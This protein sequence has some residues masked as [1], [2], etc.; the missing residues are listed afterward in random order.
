MDYATPNALKNEEEETTASTV[1]T[2]TSKTADLRQAATEKARIAAQGVQQ[3]ATQIKHAAGEKAQ[4]FRSLAKIGSLTCD[5]S[6]CACSSFFFFLFE[7]VWCCVIHFLIWLS[8]SFVV[9]K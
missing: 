9:L 1:A 2:I 3:K 4:Q 8:L 7:S 6:Y 5:R